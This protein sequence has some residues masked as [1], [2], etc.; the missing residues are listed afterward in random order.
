MYGAGSSAGAVGA[1]FRLD[2]FSYFLVVL[3][4][5]FTFSKLFWFFNVTLVFE[6][7]N[8]LGMLVVLPI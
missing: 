1:S 6:I 7:D 4:H 3:V 5:L 8:D 2:V